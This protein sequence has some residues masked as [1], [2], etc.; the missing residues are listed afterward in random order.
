MERQ[1]EGHSI[2]LTEPNYRKNVMK[3]F[4]TV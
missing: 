2:V 1:I 4:R 3:H